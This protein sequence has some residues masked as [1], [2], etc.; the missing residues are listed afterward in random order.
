MMHLVTAGLYVNGALVVTSDRNAKD[1]FNDIQPRDILEKVAALPITS[2]NY[3]QDASSRHLGS[4][5][6]GFLCC[7]GVAWMTNTS[8]RWMQMA[9][10]WPRFKG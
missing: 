3:K 5:G 1:N 7:F 8:R 6:A 4:H 9:W 10:H 2:W